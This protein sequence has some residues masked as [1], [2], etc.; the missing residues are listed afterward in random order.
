ML[1]RT[2]LTV[3][4]SLAF[5]LVVVGLVLVGLRRESLLEGRLGSLAIIGQE[6]VWTGIVTQ[7]TAELGSIAA[8]MIGQLE[9]RP[10]AENREQLRHWFDRAGQRLLDDTTVLQVT[11]KNGRLLFSSQGTFA[12]NPMLDAAS[13]DQIIADGRTVKGLQQTSATNFM[14]LV[15]VPLERQGRTLGVATLARDASV[16]LHRFANDI[17]ATAF[18][19]SLRGRM[20]EGTSPML[21]RLVEPRVPPRDPSFSTTSTDSRRFTVTGVPV[22]DSAGRVAGTLVSLRDSTSALEEIRTLGWLSLG[23]VMVFVVLVL[24]VLYFYLR[25]TFRPLESAISV[26]RALS[27][28]NTEVTLEAE[29]A[30]EIGRIADAVSVFRDNTITLADQ[31]RQSERQRRRQERLIRQQLTILASTLEGGEK[32]E[33]LKD[34]QDLLDRSKKPAEDSQAVTPLDEDEQLGLLAQVL[35]GMSA[36]ITDQHRRLTQMVAELQEA[37]VTKTKLAGL[38]QEL[39]IARRLQHSILPKGL[40][41]TDGVEV[42]GYMEPAKEVGGDFYDFFFVEPGRLGLVIA[43]VSGKGVPAAL[44]MAVSRSLLKA[45]A[46]SLKDPGKSIDRVNAVM[47]DENDEMMFVTLFYGVLDLA[48]GR[49]T[50]VNA[51]HNQPYLRHADG[52]VRMVGTLGD[53]PLAVMEGFTFAVHSEQL[54][55]GDVLLLYTDGVTEAFDAAEQAYGE[56]RLEATLTNLDKD[57]DSGTVIAAV[58]KSVEDFAAGAPQSDD[59]TMLALRWLGPPTPLDGN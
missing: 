25:R 43:D 26:L 24:T 12:D 51:G 59:T 1:L 57:A 15:A 28:G 8:R 22:Y 46:Q 33:A 19:V 32:D 31:R 47:A 44:F 58:V 29:G 13:L 48:T 5:L 11:D 45:T 49:L 3:Y 9:R 7:T 23:L 50:F 42:T 4:L 38:Q 30:G 54:A 17:E 34:M 39:E 21:W 37:I 10:P 35:K 41:P 6:S 56:A 16:D 14:V 53:V 2:R 18:L 36:Q 55:P 20:V 40:P 52:E 27:S